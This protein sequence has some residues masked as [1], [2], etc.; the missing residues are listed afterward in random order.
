MAGEGKE[1]GLVSSTGLVITSSSER[2]TLTHPVGA[3]GKERLRT[4]LSW[5]PPNRSLEV[6]RDLW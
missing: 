3:L 4:S 1:M 5:R 2:D 6:S